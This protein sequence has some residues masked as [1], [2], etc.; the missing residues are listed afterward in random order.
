[1][2]TEVSSRAQSLQEG[3]LEKKKKKQHSYTQQEPYCSERWQPKGI[4]RS[5]TTCCL[6]CQLPCSLF[7][8][9]KQ[10]EFTKLSHL[11]DRIKDSSKDTDVP[12]QTESPYFYFFLFLFQLHL[13][14]KLVRMNEAT[15]HLLM[16]SVSSKSL[17]RH[18]LPQLHNFLFKLAVSE[19]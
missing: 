4:T 11:P 13:E 9:K 19:L 7:I 17:R 5:G 16:V 14:D 1:M 8:L 10:T 2:F 12:K 18:L 3:S 15:F 6:Q